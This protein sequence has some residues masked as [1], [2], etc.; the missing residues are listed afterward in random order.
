MSNWLLV[1]RPQFWNALKDGNSWPFSDRSKA[2]WRVRVGDRFAVYVSDLQIA[3][4]TGTVVRA[5]RELPEPQHFGRRFVFTGD[6]GVRFD[7]GQRQVDMKLLVPLMKH[8]KDK[9]RWG[10]VLQAAILQLTDEDFSVMA[11]A[12]SRVPEERH[13]V[14]T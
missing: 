13:S 6:F 11:H 2:A 1:C 3:A 8:F 10:G 9:H 5:P 14:D 7:F 4:V 12:L